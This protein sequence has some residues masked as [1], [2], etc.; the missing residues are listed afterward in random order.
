MGVLVRSVK[1]NAN[2]EIVV[3]EGTD[4]ETRLMFAKDYCSQRRVKVLIR[5]IGEKSTACHK[6]TVKKTEQE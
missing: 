5:S 2:D 6:K 3:N 4:Y 1:M